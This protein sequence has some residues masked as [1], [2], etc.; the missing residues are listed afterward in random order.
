MPECGV[1]VSERPM[2][3]HGESLLCYAPGLGLDSNATSH[4]SLF[5][6][7]VNEELAKH[8]LEREVREDGSVLYRV[9]T[10]VPKEKWNRKTAI[11]LRITIGGKKWIESE[12]PVQTLGKFNAVPDEYGFLIP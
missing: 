8:R 5:G 2:P 1:V 4:Q 9:F 10:A 3:T 6:E 7:K 12:A 11:K